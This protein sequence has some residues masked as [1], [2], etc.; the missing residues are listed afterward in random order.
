MRRGLCEM[1]VVVLGE[2]FERTWKDLEGLGRT[3]GPPPQPFLA[4]ACG[5]HIPPPPPFSL[6]M[7]YLVK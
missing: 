6:V 5:G 1:W 7:Y 2:I 3:P 4:G